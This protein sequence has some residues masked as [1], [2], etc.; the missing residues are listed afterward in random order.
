MMR[1]FAGLLPVVAASLILPGC[2]YIGDFVDSEAYREDFHPTH[3]L[4]AGGAVS[5]ET[6]NGSIELRGWEQNSVEI[7][8]TKSASSK[9]LLDALK[10]EVNATPGSVRIRAVRPPDFYRNMGVRFAIRVPRK[11]LLDLI[12]SSNGRI[13]IEDV[14]GRARLRTS[15][16]GIR[17]SRLKGEVEARTS[18]GAIEA[19]DVDGNVNLHT[20]NGAIRAETTHG[21]FEGTT[22]N[23]SITARLN[24]P[25][26][27]WP[28]RAESSNGHIDLTLDAKQLPE[29]RASTSNSGILLRLPASASARVRAATSHAAVTSDFDGLQNDG[30]RRRHSE[31]H[32]TI[33]NGGPLIDLQS[34]NGSIKIM[35]L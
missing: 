30:S 2:F 26:A 29:V 35:K 18:N 34:S 3:P 19:Q 16:G 1:T 5:V 9:G 6:F 20:S 17:V 8:G 21:S 23:G 15:N 11:A 12:S 33:G 28:V 10:I 25:A 22:S 13:Q 32:G 7:N 14:E 24:D 31:A 4:E 27:N